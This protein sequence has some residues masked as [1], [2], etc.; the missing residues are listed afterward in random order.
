MQK[1]I[2]FPFYHRERFLSLN[3]KLQIAKACIM[4]LKLNNFLARQID[5]SF[6]TYFCCSFMHYN[7]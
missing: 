7:N 2:C 4:M 1:V 6:L 5:L 3:I